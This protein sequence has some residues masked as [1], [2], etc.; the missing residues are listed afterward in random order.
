MVVEI[1]S[2]ES[3]HLFE[4]NEFAFVSKSDKDDGIELIVIFK[5]GKSL[6]LTHDNKEERDINY[7]KIK[8]VWLFKGLSQDER[9]D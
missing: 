8:E 5:N 2:R 4:I 6:T 3:S 9:V 1:E 7:L